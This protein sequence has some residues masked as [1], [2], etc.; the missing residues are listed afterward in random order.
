MGKILLLV[1]P[2]EIGLPVFIVKWKI[3]NLLSRNSL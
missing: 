2:S 1:W 3:L